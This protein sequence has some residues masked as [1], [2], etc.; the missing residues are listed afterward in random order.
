[1][2]KNLIY[3]I[4][5]I[6]L[7][8][9]A[10]YF[11]RFKDKSTIRAKDRNFAIEDTS[12]VTGIRLVKFSEELSLEREENKW[13]VN[14]EVN[15]RQSAINALF[16]VLMRLQVKAPVSKS[17][18]DKIIEYLHT[19]GFEVTIYS[20]KRIV[21]YIQVYQ[22]TINNVTYMMLEG[23]RQ[24]FVMQLPG[25]SSP[26]GNL[27]IVE[28]NYW[29][30]NTVFSLN[31][32]NILLVS[33]DYP[34]EPEMSYTIENSGDDFILKSLYDDEVIKEAD[35]KK[36][37]NYLYEFNHV[38]FDDFL[39]E[40]ITNE[41]KQSM[42]KDDSRVIITLKDI[43]NRVYTVKGFP[44]PVKDTYDELGNPINYDLDRMYALVNNDKDL[45]IISYFEVS[46]ILKRLNDFF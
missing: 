33:V 19:R 1:M 45:V 29:R 5:I 2:K 17:M 9:V 41:E 15:A 16:N 39:I 3:G 18:Q 21:K 44:I 34:Y 40:D 13:I 7:G 32:R 11:F 31:V 35:R 36:I 37:L 28:K 46:G 25:Y 24:P 38:V 23:A 6:V 4:L 8:G 42:I 12:I 43:N 30:D 26:I 27:F 10:F 14:G 22:D 20:G